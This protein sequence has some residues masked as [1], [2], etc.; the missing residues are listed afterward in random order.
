MYTN[1]YVNM[2]IFIDICIYLH[3]H[4]NKHTY[5]HAFI[6]IYIYVYIHICIRIFDRNLWLTEK[7]ELESKICQM[8]AVQTQIQV[9]VNKCLFICVHI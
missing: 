2:C 4:I 3:M 7:N 6:Y 1:I 5:L 9:F 8:L